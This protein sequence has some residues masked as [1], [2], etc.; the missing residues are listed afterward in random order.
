MPKNGVAFRAQLALAVIALAASTLGAAVLHASARIED[1]RIVTSR[2]VQFVTGRVALTS[3]SA[4]VIAQVAQVM[5]TVPE[6]DFVIEAHTD[7]SGSPAKNL[8]LSQARAEAVVDALVMRGVA[9][10][11]LRAVGKGSTDPIMPRGASEEWRNR[12]V[13]ILVVDRALAVAAAPAAAAP[14]AA[15]PPAGAAPART[16]RPI[17]VGLLDDEPRPT[18]LTTPRV[19]SV[20]DDDDATS[21]DGLLALSFAAARARPR[22]GLLDGEDADLMAP[23]WHRGSEAA[24]RRPRVSTIDE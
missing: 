3:A 1:D 23:T 15:A 7:A 10:T 4:A 12:R 5:A 21:D 6:R 19:G 22:I 13:E 16:F 18:T 17:R 20:D 14:V 2:K 24:P 11:R 9:R 8:A